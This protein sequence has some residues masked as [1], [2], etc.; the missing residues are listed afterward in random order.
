M[1][2]LILIIITF[3]GLLLRV[4]GI[5]TIPVTFD[6]AF[7]ILLPK[8]IDLPLMIKG[9]AEVH[10]PL[11]FLLSHIWER[12]SD[13]LQF[14]RLLSIIFGV[15]TIPSIAFVG[16]KILDRRIGLL[17]AFL[18][19]IS[20]SQ[21]YYASI[22]RMYALAVFES[23]WIIYFFIQF[24][25]KKSNI[26]PLSVFLLLGLYTHYFFVIYLLILNIYFFIHLK[27]TKTLLKSW[28]S[29]N[30]AL[31]FLF[32]PALFIIFKA[33]PSISVP[34]INLLK[35][36]VFYIIPQIPWETIQAL[37]IFRYY[38]FD[39]PSLV[40]LFLSG[41][42]FILLGIGILRTRSNNTLRFLLFTYL[43]TPPIILLISYNFIKIAALRSFILFS[44]FFFLLIA[45]ALLSFR[46]KIQIGLIFL[47]ALI[48]L[49]YYLQITHYAPNELK[50]INNYF[51]K[52]DIVV[53]NDVTLF[54][55]TKVLKPQGKHFLIFPG[56][57]QKNA[58]KAIN[59]QITKPDEIPQSDQLWYMKQETDWPPYQEQADS[60]ENYL[61]K[62]YVEKERKTFY[63]LQLIK[64]KKIM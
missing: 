45:A 31:S 37:K 59:V 26:I 43:I 46:A 9:V 58:Y 39:F 17:A 11:Y 28:A 19:T 55:P 64:Y 22:G 52:N 51:T 33:E 4:Y 47:S 50:Q 34:N 60:L 3:L 18:F 44:P 8:T 1:N 32:I 24:L 6:E 7:N 25:N 5:F 13:N 36:P 61:K 20:P 15:A 48:P 10:P 2:L 21:I 14:I 38:Q 16:K 27:Q 56:H 54:L 35:L 41:M 49:V 12:F 63:K 30:I 23:T 57:L 53:Y 42:A 29:M 40:A 62:S